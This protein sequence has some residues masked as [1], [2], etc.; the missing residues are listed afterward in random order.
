LP[1]IFSL[2][3]GHTIGFSIPYMASNSQ[4]LRDASAPHKRGRARRRNGRL[5]LILR[6]T[7]LVCFLSAGFVAAVAAF[8]RFP[9]EQATWMVV[10]TNVGVAVAAFVL[11]GV[12]TLFRRRRRLAIPLEVSTS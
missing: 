4:R 1:L 2:T 8:K 9:M 3:A 11:Q 7:A 10:W 12:M 5:L 6:V